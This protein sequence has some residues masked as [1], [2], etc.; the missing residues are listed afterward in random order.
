[1]SQKIK[2]YLLMALLCSACYL[3]PYLLGMAF[4]YWSGLLMFWGGMVYQ[5]A[6]NAGW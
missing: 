4:P 1:M 3:T 2:W 6:V 5:W